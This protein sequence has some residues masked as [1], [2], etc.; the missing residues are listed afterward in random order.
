MKIK[1]IIVLITSLFALTSVNQASCKIAKQG[2]SH[3]SK[4]HNTQTT[5]LLD[6]YI[7]NSKSRYESMLAQ[8]V[9]IPSVSM[10]NTS[11]IN[12]NDFSLAFLSGIEDIDENAKTL[13]PMLKMAKIASQALTNAGFKAKVYPTKLFPVV[14]GELIQDQ[15]YPTV[16]IYNHLD[17]QPASAS[18]WASEP[19]KMQ[20]KDDKYLGR[21]TTDDKGPA[22]AVLFAAKYVK[23]HKIPINIKVLWEL[24]EEIGSPSFEAFLQEN[25]ANFKTDSIVVSDTIWVSRNSPAVAYGLRGLQ[26]ATIK[27]TTGVKDIHSGT[28][29]GL[30]RNPIGE[31]CEVIF[32]CYEP[33]TGHVKIPHFYDDVKEPSETEIE[34]FVNS[35]FTIDGFKQANEVNSIRTNNTKEAV[36]RLW[37]KPTFEIH[38]IKGGYIGQGIKT[39]VPHSAEAKISMRLVPN[40]DPHKIF[41][42]LKAFIHERC[43]NA[44]VES[45]GTLMP[46]LGDLNSPYMKA[47]ASAIENTF[48]KEAVFT[49]EGGS[50]G[51]AVSMNN[52]LNAPIVFLG[53]SLPEHGYHAINENFDWQQASGGIK[54]FVNYF[55]LLSADK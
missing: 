53:L 50:I 13:N 47:A 42:D 4:T 30:A 27:L 21:G 15:S 8:F 2:E 36:L 22:L 23:E 9:N 14:T 52:I 3:M 26:G 45:E 29:G 37:A 18:E 44:I 38:G 17:V 12:T 54:L 16:L 43:P 39:I 34:H 28:T 40:Q 33:K 55:E 51:A 41:N 24:E 48:K 7:Q 31:I 46:Y 35:G 6:T 5:N 49:R 25:K 20:I 10:E 32:D 11:T 1:F 19:F